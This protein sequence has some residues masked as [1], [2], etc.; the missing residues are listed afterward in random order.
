MDTGSK[1]YPHVL[2]IENG[3]IIF[4]ET[5]T[6]NPKIEGVMSHYFQLAQLKV[7]IDV[8]LFGDEIFSRVDNNLNIWNFLV[9]LLAAV[10][11][12]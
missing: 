2:L 8:C 9:L 4:H 11:C 1:A 12:L 6:K 10:A 3:I 5:Q 7:L